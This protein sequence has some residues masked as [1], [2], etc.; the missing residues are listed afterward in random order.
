MKAVF[1]ESRAF[2]RLHG[3]PEQQL[4][5]R[6]AETGFLRVLFHRCSCKTRHCDWQCSTA[7]ALELALQAQPVRLRICKLFAFIETQSSVN[8][9]PCY[10]IRH[11]VQLRA[12]YHELGKMPLC[13]PILL[14]LAVLPKMSFN[15]TL[16]CRGIPW[17]YPSR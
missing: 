3:L 2:F 5:M 11:G 6:A 7:L 15:M 4:A 17:G 9:S 13:T 10:S 12:Q 1:A 16:Y 8:E 14:L